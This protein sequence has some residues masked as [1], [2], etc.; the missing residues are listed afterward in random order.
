MSLITKQTSCPPHVSGTKKPCPLHPG[1]K[2]GSIL[3]STWKSA[4]VSIWKTWGRELHLGWMKEEKTW[5]EVV[6]GESDMSCSQCSRFPPRL[7]SRRVREN[8]TSVPFWQIS[9]DPGQVDPPAEIAL[10]LRVPIPNH[11]LFP[12][13]S[14]S[15]MRNGSRI[16]FHHAVWG[17]LIPGTTIFKD[18]Q[19]FH[20]QT[21]KL[22]LTEPR[23]QESISGKKTK[24][25][26]ESQG[27]WRQLQPGHLLYC[28]SIEGLLCRV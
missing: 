17:L 8:Q 11:T 22:C 5:V 9:K 15:L 7:A 6:C 14:W 18:L 20:P 25:R 3:W 23:V 28:P 24:W 4:V 12:G 13:H 21:I 2:G 19:F 1:Q 10:L 26:G 16:P 27:S